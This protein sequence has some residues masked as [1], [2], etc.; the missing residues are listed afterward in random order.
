M[1]PNSTVDPGMEAVVRDSSN[2]LLLACLEQILHEPQ[3]LLET[4]CGSYRHQ[5]GFVKIALNN[6]ASGKA[7]RLHLWDQS[8]VVTE[9]IHSHCADFMSRVVSG[10]LE[11]H[12]YELTPGKAFTRFRYHFDADAGHALAHADGFTDVL[13]TSVTP[14]LAGT[15]YGRRSHELHT[16]ANIQDSTMTV[17]AWGVRAS[18]AVVIKPIGARAEDCGAIA[19]MPLEDVKNLLM[20]ICRRLHA[21]T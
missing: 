21:S 9:D 18:E 4:A 5:L 3:R 14:L 13:Q 20:Y 2:S 11:E 19:G 8:A 15:I 7:L 12:R 6:D 17:S 10:G 16:V 1:N